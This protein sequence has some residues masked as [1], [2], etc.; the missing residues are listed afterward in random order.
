MMVHIPQVLTP[1]QVA[2]CRAVFD[3]AAWE[4]GRTTAGKQSMQVKKNLQLSE[5]SP[6][7]RELGDLV[8]AGL[9]KSPLF[10]SAVLPQRVF[11]PLFNRYEHGMDFGSHVDNAIRP[12]LGTNQRIRTDVSATLFL[13]DPDS[14]DGGELVVED[15]YGNHAAKLPAGDLI[16]Y[17]STSLH[18]VTPVTRGVRLASFF[19]IQSMIRDA[20][21]RSLLFDMDTSI[22]Q[23]TREVPKSPALVMLTGV[24]HN[25]LRQWA[26]P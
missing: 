20:G 5:G 4:D 2:H 26:E 1:E 11:P 12:I 19:W 22:M 21:Q 25:L 10:I 24:Y 14:Y 15:T 7:A 23:L 13:S 9:E 3:K 16:V 6:A 18:H 8:L 17:P